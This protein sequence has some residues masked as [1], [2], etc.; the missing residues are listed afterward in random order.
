MGLRKHRLGSHLCV[1]EALY[2][3]GCC[4]RYFKN[5]MKVL[6]RGLFLPWCS[7]RQPVGNEEVS[8]TS[9]LAPGTPCC[10]LSTHTHQVLMSP[11]RVFLGMGIRSTNNVT[12]QKLEL[13]LPLC[14]LFHLK[15]SL[16]H[17]TG[18]ASSLPNLGSDTWALWR[19]FA[20]LLHGLQ[21]CAFHQL[22]LS[23]SGAGALK[24]D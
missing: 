23:W 8:L 9:V 11:F 15:G 4:H 14:R 13:P 3:R 17:L 10:P 16:Q 22:T 21:V 6:W 20:P 2:F 18:S 7:P 12:F 1:P 24:A 5:E 19:S